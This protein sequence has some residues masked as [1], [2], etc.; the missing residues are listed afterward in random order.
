M[1]DYKGEIQG[2]SCLDSIISKANHVQDELSSLDAFSSVSHSVSRNANNPSEVD[3]V[4]KLREGKKRYTLGSTINRQGRLG[5]EASA[6]FPNLLGTLSTSRLSV[7]TFGSNSRELN[8]SHFTPRIFSN[9]NMVYSLSKSLVDYS[10]S[11]AYTESSFGSLVRLSDP[12]GRHNFA[13]ESR[14]RELPRSLHNQIEALSQEH[15]SSLREQSDSQGFQ[16]LKNSLCYSWN[17]IKSNTNREK[18]HPTAAPLKVLSS[19]TTQ[20]LCLE[21]AGFGGDVCFVKTQG[22]YTWSSKLSTTRENASL[23][24]HLN[25]GVHLGLGVLLPNLLSTPPLKTSMHDRFFLGGNCGAHYCLPGFA[26]RSVGPCMQVAG[27]FLRARGGGSEACGERENVCLGSDAFVSS[28]LRVS[29]PIDLSR[30]G[31][32]VRPN[33]EAHVSGAVVLDKGDYMDGGG[34]SLLRRFGEGFRAAAGLGL[35]VPFGPA[36]LSLMFS[37]PIKCQKTDTPEGFQL[38]MRMTYAPL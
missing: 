31:V 27:N 26:P 3:V 29:H 8:V 37:A 2:E 18:G 17:R 33:L 20:Q 19:T 32:D 35:S 28:E 9:M 12:A 14:I 30:A 1:E 34:R 23:L 5:F 11:S 21:I 4:F 25:M 10:K 15:A 13:I 16:T 36:N 22:F 7:E 38:G 6:F 24:K